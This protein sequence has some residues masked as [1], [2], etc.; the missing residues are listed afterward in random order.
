MPA[1]LADAL[2]LPPMVPLSVN[3][4]PRRTCYTVSVDAVG[5]G[6]GISAADR[7]RTCNV[8]AD[9]RVRADALVRP[10]HIL[11]LRAVS[12][13]V[14]ARQGHTEAA[15]ELCRLAGLREVGVI[16]ELV[17]DGPD[18]EVSGHGLSWTAERA[19]TGMMRRDQC[20]AFGRRF[21][22]K[23]ITIDALV[24]YI[25]SQSAVKAAP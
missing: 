3:A 18:E 1:T 20:L 9:P 23:V 17:D 7:A 25:K 6:T 4:D 16:G 5:T 12:G 21:G 11:P 8:L 14:L 10:G 13:G 19:G 15:V 2:D 24:E 22:I